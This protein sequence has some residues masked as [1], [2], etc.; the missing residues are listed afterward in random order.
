MTP[1]RKIILEEIANTNT[2]PSAD[3]IYELVRRRLP[4]I[5]LGTVYRN[6][7]VL[8]ECGLIRKMDLGDGHWRFDGNAESHYHVRCTSCGRITDLYMEELCDFENIIR[9]QTGYEGVGHRL[10]FYGLCPVC[11]REREIPHRT[12]LP[13]SRPGAA[14]ESEGM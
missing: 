2:H 11:K 3:E 14:G 9:Q 7:E 1:Q 10:D 5:S 13:S 8:C 6:L 4:R 12:D